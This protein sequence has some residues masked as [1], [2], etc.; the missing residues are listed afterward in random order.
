[1]YGEGQDGT[2]ATKIR[3]SNFDIF[4]G[5]YKLLSSKKKIV[6]QYPMNDICRSDAFGSRDIEAQ[7]TIVMT[8]AYRLIPSQS[9][10]VVE[11][12]SKGIFA[13][14]EHDKNTLVIPIYGKVYVANEEDGMPSTV[15]CF[16][17][18]AHGFQGK[19]VYV[20][21]SAATD[22]GVTPAAFVKV[23]DDEEKATAKIEWKSI[24]FFKE[25]ARA[26]GASKVKQG[27]RMPVII[28]HCYLDMDAEVSIYREP[29]EKAK[30]E[31]SKNVAVDCGFMSKRLRTA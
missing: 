19:L 2:L 29:Q 31:P 6:L 24:A 20:K 12:P 3:R 18:K 8:E 5:K 28:N 11:K 26:K 14:E 25:F 4:L 21:T 10:M 23:V 9:I 30:K 13:K 15:G 17:V 16:E 27:I 22:H 1:M 7:I